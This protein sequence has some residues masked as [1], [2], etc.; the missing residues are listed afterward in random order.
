MR[1]FKSLKKKK[2]ILFNT[3]LALYVGINLIGGERGLISFFDK[4]KIYHDLVIKEEKLSGELK[5]LD[6]ELKMKL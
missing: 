1:L 3:F 2:F 4:K 6:M 5:N